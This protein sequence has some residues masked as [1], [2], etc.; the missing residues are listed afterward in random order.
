MNIVNRI[1]MMTYDGQ[2][3]GLLSIPQREPYFASL[4]HCTFRNLNPANRGARNT[5]VHDVY[6]IILVTGGRGTFVVGKNKYPV[7]SGQ[8][9]LTSP[10]EW[11]SFFNAEGEDAEYCEATFEFRN[12]AGRALTI[13]F[14]AA[15]SAWTGK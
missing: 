15:L 7:E 12:R 8:L 14:H 13:P 10:G 1:F 3:P 9:F 6:H 11:H 2:P 5:H 4:L